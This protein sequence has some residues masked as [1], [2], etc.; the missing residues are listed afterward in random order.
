[1]V[2]PKLLYDLFGVKPTATI[3]E[4]EEAYKEIALKFHLDR[5]PDIGHG[6]HA[7]GGK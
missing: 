7:C 4:I 1:M 5:N 6:P 3:E 2:D